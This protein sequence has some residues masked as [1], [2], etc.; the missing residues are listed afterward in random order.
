VL[1]GFVE[2]FK[3]YALH[4]LAIIRSAIPYFGLTKF[5]TRSCSKDLKK[6]LTFIIDARDGVMRRTRNLIQLSQFMTF[7]FTMGHSRNIQFE[8]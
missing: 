1:I 5:D 7:N 8:Q 4:R 3:I 6:T 2:V